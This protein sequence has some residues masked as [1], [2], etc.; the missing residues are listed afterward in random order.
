MAVPREFRH[1]AGSRVVLTGA[2]DVGAQGGRVHV[3]LHG[4]D[5]GSVD[6][7]VHELRRNVP[8]EP[9]VHTCGA[10]RR[11]VLVMPLTLQE[12]SKGKAAA[13]RCLVESLPDDGCKRC[14]ILRLT[15][16]DHGLH[17]EEDVPGW[18]QPDKATLQASIFHNETREARE[19]GDYHG[20]YI[21]GCVHPW[22]GA[23][24]RGGC[25]VERA[26]ASSL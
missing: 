26:C 1:V 17:D 7:V 9:K 24:E 2:S 16:L 5:C 12:R 19:A 23:E 13:R 10:R 3:G 18:N 4:V 21:H 8:R 6:G 15:C 20:A 11:A 14:L 22:R 25:Q